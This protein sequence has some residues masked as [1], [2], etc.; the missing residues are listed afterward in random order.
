M[1]EQRAVKG[2]IDLAAVRYDKSTGLVPVVVQDV[3]TK[4]VLMLA[5]ANREALKRTFST[6]QSWFWSRSR[7]EYWHKGATSGHVQRV[8]EIRLDCDGDTVL[9]LVR[10]EGPA[11]HTGETSCFHRRLTYA[12][13]IVDP[14]SANSADPST[15][16]Q[17]TA[18]PAQPAE[19]RPSPE[20]ASAAAD[21]GQLS[22]LWETIDAR[23]RDRPE[24][25]YSSYLF[26]HGAEKIGKKVGEEATEVALA[27]LRAELTG[28][29]RHVATES[30]D[31][32]YHLLVLW[33]AVGT[34]PEDVFAVLNSRESR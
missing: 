20:P 11:C 3:D 23:Y 10:P 27:A 26:D 13:A 7:Q 8:V 28:A 17:L 30:A 14:S 2:G 5:Y 32:I 4:D 16:A 6:G 1:A 31:L 34:S 9:Y 19:M 12:E 22:K 33:R 29:G 15:A 24:G 21:W 18:I 25:S